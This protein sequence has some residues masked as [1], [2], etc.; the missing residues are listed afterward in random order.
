LRQHL[1]ERSRALLMEPEG[2]RHAAA[3]C[4]VRSG[5]LLRAAA[6]RGL[7]SRQ[8]T[9][10]SLGRRTGRGFSGVALAVLWLIADPLAAQTVMAERVPVILD[11]KEASRLIVNQVKPE[12]PPLAKMN[13]IQGS[14]R[15]Q[16]LVTDQGQVAEA[17][18]I[19][20]HPFLAAEA[21]HAVQRWVYRPRRNEKASGGFL[22][23]VDVHF[24]LHLRQV[25][26]V[27]AQPERDL[28]RQ[29]QPPT[30]VEKPK[31]SATVNFVRVRV[32]VGTDG[33]AIDSEPVSGPPA[34][35]AAA[36]KSVARWK[37]RPARWGNQAVPWY[38]DVEVP[39]E[40][41]DAAQSNGGPAGS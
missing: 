39:M 15:M 6:R 32:L 31:P 9:S 1:L 35:F 40:A 4:A 26:R 7:E 3:S 23:F 29:V 25:E 38:M 14:V 37:F 12:Y 20:G 19:R 24:A 17:H 21:L 13:Y 2:F 28:F 18:V 8:P 41:G 36:R 16:L 27:P 30:V 22:T 33:R 5:S 34:N 11:S 10:G